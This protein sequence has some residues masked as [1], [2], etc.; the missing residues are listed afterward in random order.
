MTHQKLK[1]LKDAK[2]N[3]KPLLFKNTLNYIF[4]TCLMINCSVE[5]LKRLRR[6]RLFRQTKRKT[7]TKII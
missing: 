1:C 3:M 5:L 6:K 7:K 4:N 2:E